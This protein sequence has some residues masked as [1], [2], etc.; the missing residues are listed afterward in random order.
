MES[1]CHF[2][3]GGTC[4]GCRISGG[5]YPDCAVKNCHKENGVKFCCECDGFTCIRNNYNDELSK[6]WKDNNDYMKKNGIKTF[7]NYQKKLPMY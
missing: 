6:K 2:F 4:E 1:R 3:S 5:K 7:Y